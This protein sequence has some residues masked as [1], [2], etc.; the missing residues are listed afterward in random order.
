MKT[1][2]SRFISRQTADDCEDI[3]KDY[4]TEACDEPDHN[5]RYFATAYSSQP[6]T[7]ILDFTDEI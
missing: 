1:L 7:P 2:A 3:L 6:P 5:A 4:E